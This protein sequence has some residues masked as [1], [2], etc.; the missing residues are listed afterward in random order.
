MATAKKLASGSWR[1]QVYSHTEETVQPDGTIKKKRIYKSFTCDVKG[2]KGK[3]ICE[4]MAAEWAENKENHVKIQNITFGE[5]VNNY[6]QSRVPVLSPLTITGYK[7]ILKNNLQTLS[8]IN[9][10]N[11]NQADIQRTINQEAIK[12]SPKT[13]RNIHGLIT[14]VLRTYRP[15]LIVRTVLPAKV[16]PELH[17]PS[18]EEIKILLNAVKDTELELPVLL[19]AF[20]PMRRGEIC[21]LRVENIKGN[22]VH[23]CENMIR[24]NNREWIIK[25]PKSY[26]GDRYIAYPD[27]VA[28]KWKNFNSGRIVLLNPDMI[29]NRFGKILKK[30]EIPHFRFHDLRH[31]SAS[32]LHAIGVP[33][34]Y[35]MERGGWGNDSV[36]K[37]VYRHTMEE[38]QKQLSNIANTHFNSLYETVYN[39]TYN[40][41]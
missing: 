23:V 34:A 8:N 33:D 11:L 36:L 15:D 39:T 17:I 3:R 35:I 25:S 14:A 1:C 37:S 18:D 26:A 41:N 24:D 10:Q 7:Q 28:E 9:I 40:T 31:Y 19:A 27:F 4:K 30:Y 16:R 2:P 29:T 5:A 32:V 13:V 6:I 38:K 12:H 21:A 22:T 20:G